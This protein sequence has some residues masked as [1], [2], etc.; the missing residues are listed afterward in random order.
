MSAFK[1]SRRS[2]GL[3]FKSISKLS[4]AGFIIFLYFLLAVFSPDVSSRIILAMVGS[5]LKLLLSIKPNPF[6]VP[7]PLLEDPRIA[8]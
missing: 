3:N 4:A 5:L 7:R 2:S 6:S 8:S 1:E